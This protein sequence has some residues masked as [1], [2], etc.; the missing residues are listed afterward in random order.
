MP[1]YPIGNGTIITPQWFNDIQNRL[2]NSDSGDYKQWLD[3]D[4]SDNAGQIKSRLATLTDEFKVTGM[5][6][7]YANING[8]KAK[9]TLG[10]LIIIPN[11]TVLCTDNAINYI[12][13]NKDGSINSYTYIQGMVLAKVTLSNGVLVSNEDMRAR[14]LLFD[15][16]DIQKQIITKDISFIASK[17]C[18][19]LITPSQDINIT[20]PSNNTPGDN[21]WVIIITSQYSV[22]LQNN[23]VNVN[24]QLSS[25]ILSPN[26][27]YQ[28]TFI[29]DT[30]GWYCTISPLN[31]TIKSTQ[32]A[33]MPSSLIASKILQVN[34]TADQYQLVDY[35]VNRW[36]LAS[37]DYT[38][39]NN[40][41]IFANTTSA[42]FAVNLP[43]SPIAGDY[44]EIFGNFATNNL[45]VRRN[46]LTIDGAMQ[47]ITLSSDKQICRF[48]YSGSTW[49]SSAGSAV[50]ESSGNAVAGVIGNSSSVY[51]STLL[52]N[53]IQGSGAMLNDTT[54]LCLIAYGAY[55]NKFYIRPALLNTDDSF[56]FYPAIVLTDVAREVKILRVSN[57]QA[58]VVYYIPSS[59]QVVIRLI[60]VA[61]N[62][63][64]TTSQANISGALPSYPASW[65]MVALPADNILA[66]FQAVYDNNVLV[67]TTGADSYFYTISN[68]NV[69]LSFIVNKTTPCFTQPTT[70]MRS[71]N[72]WYL[73]HLM[74]YGYQYNTITAASA[75]AGVMEVV[76][77]STQSL[78]FK[79]ESGVNWGGGGGGTFNV[80]KVTPSGVIG[81]AT[82]NNTFG[83]AQLTG[84]STGFTPTTSS[85]FYTLT[86]NTGNSFIPT[87]FQQTFIRPY[88]INQIGN[89]LI[90]L[91]STKI[92]TNTQN[93]TTGVFATSPSA[94]LLSLPSPSATHSFLGRLTDNKAC[95][96]TNGIIAVVYI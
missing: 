15:I 78:V 2:Y 81:A 82:T 66:A 13:L 38:A 28:L 91:S 33:D 12:C 65:S 10:N 77:Q 90:T 71:N 6:G 56:S 31:G 32:L 74:Y 19:H 61:N 51:T 86:S 41:R 69:V 8:G 35:P 34:L 89:K 29:S 85:P 26:N 5:T 27:I 94:N 88:F 67:V 20:L 43:A 44:I 92:W 1:Y 30:I 54:K 87:D 37:N 23:N 52:S 21:F 42:A 17:N 73:H 60:T 59:N 84:S 49:V 45:T 48:F 36:T 64:T 68:N 16:N 18:T 9:D 63:A 40:D 62:L 50:A 95:I 25:T 76:N 79:D 22:T 3:S 11:G 55:D 47:N 96:V 93:T 46:G 58:F 57:T 80:P 7:L 4:L 72:Y 14:W 24:N 53:A 70:I 39:L 83:I 75:I